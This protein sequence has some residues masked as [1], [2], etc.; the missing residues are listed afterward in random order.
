MTTKGSRRRPLG[1][2]GSWM[3][4]QRAPVSGVWIDQFGDMAEFNAG[5]TFPPCTGRKRTCA[6]RHLIRATQQP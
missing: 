6:Y 5:H 2:H 3:T 1:P 4:G